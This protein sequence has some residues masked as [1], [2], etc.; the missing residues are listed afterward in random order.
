MNQNITVAIVGAGV[1]GCSCAL[2]LQIKGFRVILID[3]EPAGSGT[4]SGNAC[5][6]ADYACMP[7]N[8]PSIFKG[9]PGLMLAGD[10]PLSV[11]LSYAFR[12]L[13]WM[14]SFLSNCRASKVAYISR[15]LAKLLH[16]TY[17]GLDP[18]IEY[19]DANS[20]LRRQ[21]CM[22]V[23]Q[24]D[25]EFE[26][27]SPGN[28]RRRKLGFD[29]TEL[30]ANEIR[31]LEPGIKKQFARGL[32]FENATQVVDPQALT[33]R[34]FD[35]FMKNGGEYIACRVNAV[36]HCDKSLKVHLDSGE[37][38]DADRAVIAAG[39]FSRQVEGIGTSQLPLDTERGYHVQYS[40]YQTLLNRPV[41]WNEAG[42]YATPM[43]K[44]LRIV[45]TVEI[46][47]LDKPQNPKHLHYLM[48]RGRQMF[49]LPDRPDQEWM[50]Y[51]PTLPDALPVIGYSLA[52][53]YV[54]YAFGHQH[55]GL[56]LSGITGKL[57][58]ELI[59]GETPSHDIRAFSARRFL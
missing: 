55:I 12:R 42:F 9:L 57:I 46:A 19:C 56:T 50:G 36:S 26:R 48:N 32:L 17:E 45:G 35:T 54:L 21:G 28:Q 37:S 22:Y 25:V 27:A 40:G 7:V 20:L 5:T 43:D 29:F 3:P 13:P 1:V 59:N 41:S 11:D 30:D 47:G 15:T 14:L 34:Y 58:S 49:E 16:G 33:N 51:R 53:E 18:L 52:S 8:N 44:G 31:E 4:S 10:S 39:A 23:Y 2:W 38:I 24:D 6:I